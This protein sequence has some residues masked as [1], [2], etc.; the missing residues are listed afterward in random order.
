MHSPMDRVPVYQAGGR[1]FKS[2]PALQVMANLEDIFIGSAMKSTRDYLGI[3]MMRSGRSVVYMPC[4][5]RFWVAQTY[6][7]HGGKAERVVASDIGLFPA[8][9]GNLADPGKDLARLNLEFSD[10]VPEPNRPQMTQEGNWTLKQVCAVIDILEGKPTVT[11]EQLV[12]EA[13]DRGQVL[14]EKGRDDC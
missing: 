8:V 13:K 1:W 7:G 4:V 11:R 14:V 6:L 3:E 2:S 10:S 9:V 5:G 12:V